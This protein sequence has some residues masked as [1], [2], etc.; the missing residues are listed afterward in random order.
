MTG[1]GDDVEGLG[2]DGQSAHADTA[3]RNLWRELIE[4]LLAA[5]ERDARTRARRNR[6]GK[7]DLVAFEN[8]APRLRAALD[9]GDVPSD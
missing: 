3:P 4:M 2:V 8:F 6:R 7:A 1:R 9:R 5:L